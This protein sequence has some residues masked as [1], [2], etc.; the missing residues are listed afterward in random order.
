MQLTDYFRLC[1]EK[2]IQIF[3][4]STF[5][6]ISQEAHY[7][8]TSAS[9]IRTGQR[10]EAWV[11]KC[12]KR[13]VMYFAI[14]LG[15][16]VLICYFL[17]DLDESVRFVKCNQSIKSCVWAAEPI[18]QNMRLRLRESANM[19][20]PKALMTETLGYTLHLLFGVGQET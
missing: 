4:G 9:F 8:C 7:T 18:F 6:N 5:G 1:E 2:K 3:I 19:G 20:N 14:S 12:Y 17:E 13:G 15:K 10:A 11:T 16:Q